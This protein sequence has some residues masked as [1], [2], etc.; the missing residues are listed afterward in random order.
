MFKK[1]HSSVLVSLT[2]NFEQIIAETFAFVDSILE[3]VSWVYSFV[4]YPI[5]VNRMS[6]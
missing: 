3:E 6:L 1:T 5:V 2:A 4:Q